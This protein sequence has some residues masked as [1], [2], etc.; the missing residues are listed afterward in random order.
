MRARPL[1]VVGLDLSLT[2]TGMS[3]G[4]ST[5]VVQTGPDTQLEE[6]L[7]F[8]IQDVM[9]FILAAPL[10]STGWPYGACANL[11]VIEAGAFSRGAQSAAAE[12]LSALRILVRHRLWR[13]DIP[14]A[15]VA[16]TTLK[17]YV[18]DN[19]GAKKQQMVAAVDARYGTDLASVKVKD[20][21]YDRADALGLAAMGYD[22]IGQPLHHSPDAS[23]RGRASLDAVVWPEL[24]SD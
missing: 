1:R 6:R 19:G 23:W 11:A 12:Y 13:L 20:G 4:R 21:R 22:R 8:I 17:L 10:G 16:P 9:S 24:L 2:S 3:D 15:M 18:A 5:R 14:F 7:D